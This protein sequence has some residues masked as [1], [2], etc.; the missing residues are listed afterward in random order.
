MKKTILTIFGALAIF[1]SCSDAYEIDQPGLVTEESKV[2]TNASS[3]RRG[4]MAI[5]N[6]ITP[7][8]EIKFQSVFTDEVGLGFGNGGQGIN[9]GSFN[10]ILEPGN[11]YAQSIWYGNYS[12][13]NQANRILSV[14]DRLIENETNE[15]N[16]LSLK[17]S[18]AELLAIRSYAN[19]KLFSYFTPD[20]TN[21]SGLSVMKLDFL[22]TDDFRKTIPR[23][24]VSEIK[25]FIEKDIQDANDLYF[26]SM[27]YSVTENTFF[28][29]GA[30]DAIL[31]KLYT[32]TGD[33]DKVET[34]ASK[35]IG[36]V[37]GFDSAAEYVNMFLDQ[38][39]FKN[40]VIFRLVRQPN[41]EQFTIAD[42]W[43]TNRIGLNGSVLF[44]I[45]R[46]LY[47]DL[48]KLDPS[49]TGQPTWENFT[50][51]FGVTTKRRVLRKDV[52]YNVNLHFDSSPIANYS[53]LN[54]DQYIAQDRLLIGKYVERDQN[55]ATRMQNDMLV[56]RYTDMLLSLAEARAASGNFIGT[57]ANGNYSN[58]ASIIYNIRKARLNITDFPTQ[59]EPAS[60]PVITNSQTAWKAILDE[61]RVEFAFE[62]YRYL[63]MKRIG[64]KANAGFV[65]DAQ[66][67]F[68]NSAC[69]LPAN[70][71]KLTMPIPRAEI[72][73]NPNIAPNQN[74]G[75]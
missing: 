54:Y 26:G 39:G 34:I 58:V 23:A 30:L 60:M 16:L 52:R 47:N 38:T 67:C 12:I 35:F 64:Q 69:N 27:P 57:V 62:G 17:Q 59:T 70:D 21:P 18:K 7:E 25:A 3:V 46:S 15:G 36:S 41:Q 20:Y 75:Y 74:P 11:G 4:V 1:T 63:D 8:N 28:T 72:L 9:D 71:H 44:E 31:V 5:Y 45:G 42:I 22:H 66:D 32:M 6:L 65:R 29:K 24:S 56:F 40:E 73:S 61:R 48:D 53:S 10:F 55:Q 43:Y 33:Y 68:R 14:I 51:E 50:N 37:H 49:K 19:L 2:F 13:I